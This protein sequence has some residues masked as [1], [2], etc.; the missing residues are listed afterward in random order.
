MMVVIALHCITMHHITSHHIALHCI[1]P[2]DKSDPFLFFYFLFF[3]LFNVF[4][5]FKFFSVHR[6]REDLSDPGVSETRTPRIKVILPFIVNGRT[7][8]ILGVRNPEPPG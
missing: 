7:S 5:F 6:E 4:I 1:N 3:Y 8:P 2:Q